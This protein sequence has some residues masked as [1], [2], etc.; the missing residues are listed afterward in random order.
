MTK[1]IHYLPLETTIDG[2]T[3][4]Q[5]V[6]VQ[7]CAHLVGVVKVQFK[8][9]TSAAVRQLFVDPEYRKLGIGSE[10]MR[11][12]I[13]AAMSAGCQTIALN[14]AATNRGTFPFYEKL[15]FVAT[16]EHDDGDMILAKML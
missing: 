6:A 10:M 2:R 15:G 3:E 9:R 16:F 13:H 12:C 1:G 7:E 4:T 5:I 8:E 14:L 11:L